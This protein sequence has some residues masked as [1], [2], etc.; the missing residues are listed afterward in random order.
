MN[1]TTAFH[2]EKPEDKSLDRE[3]ADFWE[4]FDG[5]AAFA[6]ESGRQRHLTTS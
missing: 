3:V 6:D 5:R 4:Q 1:E 2:L